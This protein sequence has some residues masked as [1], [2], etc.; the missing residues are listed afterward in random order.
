MKNKIQSI[1]ALFAFY[2]NSDIEVMKIMD[3]IELLT[4][5]SYEIKSKLQTTKTNRL[6][7][8]IYFIKLRK[9]E[10]NLNDI[11]NGK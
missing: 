10:N 11:L 2:M 3:R 6:T 1:A 5:R 8:L 9:I 7:R 4:Q